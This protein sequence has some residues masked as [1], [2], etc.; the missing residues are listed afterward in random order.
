MCGKL[1]RSSNF[2]DG[3][4]GEH[5]LESATQTSLEI[6]P[7]GGHKGRT[8][9][10]EKHPL[11]NQERKVLRHAAKTVVVRLGTG[12]STSTFE[13]ARDSVIEAEKELELARE[14][15][16]F[17]RREFELFAKQKDKVDGKR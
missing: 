5:V 13:A 6:L 7:G 3:A 2:L 16:E 4:V 14:E 8:F 15:V 12:Q 17:R 1:S 10:W 9:V 11:T